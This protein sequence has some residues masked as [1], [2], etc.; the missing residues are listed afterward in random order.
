MTLTELD[1]LL[2][3]AEKILYSGE[4]REEEKYDIIFS[5]RFRGKVKF[6]W[7]DPD[8]TYFE[9]ARAWVNGLREFIEREHRIQKVLGEVE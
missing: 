8:T 6:D 1:I 7:F 2:E 9:D 5:D 3:K 4:L